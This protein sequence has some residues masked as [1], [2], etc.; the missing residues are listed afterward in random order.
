MDS[1]VRPRHI[2][3]MLTSIADAAT[4]RLV[5]LALQELGPAPEPFVFVAMGSQGRTEVTLAADQDNAIIFAPSGSGDLQAVA[6]YF[7]RLGARVSD[8]LAAAGYPYCRG[9]VMASQPRWC[10]SL[11]AWRSLVDTWMDRAEPQDV[12]DLS[13]LLDQR[14]VYGD[15]GLSRALRE[16]VHDA[17][18]QAPAVLYQLTRN[19]LTFRPPS[20]PL[21]GI[22]PG[23]A[24][25]AEVDLK[26]ALMPIVTFARVYAARHGIAATHTL[27][28]IEALAADDAL[29]SADRDEIE[30]VYD[31]LL[32]ARL[33]AQLSA[34]RSGLT[35]TSVVQ[36]SR[37]GTTQRELLRGAYARIAAVQAQIAYEFPEAG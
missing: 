5:E 4:E 29:P 25:D 23:G 10:R 21:V 35:A 15:A 3:D 28:R 12:A 8:G 1:S 30:A 17:V 6:D 11:A 2:T 22:L 7:G 32:R 24:A 19:A 13:V 9:H 27:E 20:R 36:P 16:H 14:I 34:I 31:F 37:L 33:Q 18:A 26:D